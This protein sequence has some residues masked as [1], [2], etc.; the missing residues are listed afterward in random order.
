MDKVGTPGTVIQFEKRTGA[1]I[2][3]QYSDSSPEKNNPRFMLTDEEV[4]DMLGKANAFIGEFFPWMKDFV[5]FQ[6][7]DGTIRLDVADRQFL[8]FPGVEV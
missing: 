1:Y 5:V 7:S 8:E 3:Y 2:N 4:K 6:L